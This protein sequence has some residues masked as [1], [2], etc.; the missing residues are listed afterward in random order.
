MKEEEDMKS[1]IQ[2]AWSCLPSLHMHMLYGGSRQRRW[3]CYC[4]HNKNLMWWFVEFPHPNTQIYTSHFC[5]LLVSTSLYQPPLPSLLK[6]YTP[7]PIHASSS[8]QMF[9][10]VSESARVPSQ[11]MWELPAV[12][13]SLSG[14]VMYVSAS[15]AG[16]LHATQGWP[17]GWVAEE[18]KEGLGWGEKE[19][20]EEKEEGGWTGAVMRPDGFWGCASCPISWV[21]PNPTERCPQ[22]AHQTTYTHTHW[23]SSLG[24][25]PLSHIHAHFSHLT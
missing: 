19:E 17:W 6:W 3:G 24:I 4:K 9:P 2:L 14:V 5:Q 7:S 11:S 20:G 23:S 18:T 22:S 25:H 12:T 10:L 13:S 8:S 15:G 16:Q 21:A 1:F